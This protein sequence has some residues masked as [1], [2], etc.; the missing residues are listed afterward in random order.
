[1]FA[2]LHSASY[3]TKLGIIS[4]NR[5]THPSQGTR[6]GFNYMKRQYKM[7]LCADEFNSSNTGGSLTIANSN[8]F[9]S[10]RNSSES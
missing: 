1:M 6:E 4:S 8:C 9:L 2:H 10:L 5:G 3:R 7:A